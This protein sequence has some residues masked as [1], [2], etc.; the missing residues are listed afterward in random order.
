VY[1]KTALVGGVTA[2]D[3]KGVRGLC[4]SRG[5]AVNAERHPD[6]RAHD[7]RE[8]RRVSAAGAKRIIVPMRSSIK[9]HAPVGRIGLRS[10]RAAIVRKKKTT[11]TPMQ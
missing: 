10:Q 4:H 6:K 3:S 11:S 1:C 9:R 7:A 5:V 8:N 2:L